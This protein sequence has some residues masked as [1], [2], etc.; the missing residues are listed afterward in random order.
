MT[1]AAPERVMDATT[2]KNGIYHTQ[3]QNK[4]KVSFILPFF[5]IH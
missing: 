1:H 2:V 5:Y 3:K 4:K